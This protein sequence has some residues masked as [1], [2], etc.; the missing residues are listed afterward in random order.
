[1]KG[2]NTTIICSFTFDERLES[3]RIV[4][5]FSGDNTSYDSLHCH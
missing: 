1:M 2:L 5:T 3:F 4:A